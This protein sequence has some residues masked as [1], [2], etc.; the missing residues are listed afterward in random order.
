MFSK[1]K[2]KVIDQ[3]VLL[4]NNGFFQKL[5]PSSAISVTPELGILLHHQIAVIAPTMNHGT[6]AIRHEYEVAAANGAVIA[7]EIAAQEPIIAA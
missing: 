2:N 7:K 4:L 3:A 1:P 5:G 6:I